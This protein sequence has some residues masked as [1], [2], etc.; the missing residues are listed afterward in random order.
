MRKYIT[1]AMLLVISFTCSYM[2]CDKNDNECN[3]T[4][5]G[6]SEW[7]NAPATGSVNTDI[8][9]GIRFVVGNGCGSFASFSTV[10]SGDT[11][12]IKPNVNFKGCVCTQQV[13]YLDS[14]Y[15]FRTSIPGRY[16]FEALD[17]NQQFIYD[18]IDIN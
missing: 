11:I 18:S 12:A 9:I 13:F 10:T 6:P 16:Y 2:S 3:S 5:V 14:F 17:V 8:P 1:I 15:T 4:E 7:L